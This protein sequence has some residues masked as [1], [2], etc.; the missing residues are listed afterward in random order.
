MKTCN[1]IGG[2]ILIIAAVFLVSGCNML[3]GGDIALVKKGYLNSDK[4]LTVGQAFDGYKYFSSKEWKA[5][6][7]EQGRRVVEFNGIMDMNNNEVKHAIE[8]DIGA[9]GGEPFSKSRVMIQFVINGDNS[10]EI[11]GFEVIGTLKNGKSYKKRSD[12]VDSVT[13]YIYKNEISS[14]DLIYHPNTGHGYNEYP[15]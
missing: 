11:S 6:K 8:K 4:S 3:W 5:F 15:S 9:L 2:V 10:Y 14:W 12:N 7:T 13:E 1:F